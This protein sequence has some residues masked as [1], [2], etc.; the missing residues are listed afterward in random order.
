MTWYIPLEDGQ[1][2]PHLGAF[3]APPPGVNCVVWT[4]AEL[5]AA[6]SETEAIQAPDWD[7]FNGWILGDQDFNAVY[8]Q[9]IAN[10]AIAKANALF[11]AYTQVASGSTQTFA[12]AFNAVCEAGGATAQARTQWATQAKA[13]HLPETFCQIIKGDHE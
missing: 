2:A 8:G 7:G 5:E 1:P 6:R 4:D 12:T 3:S 10:G 9:A 13:M 11:V